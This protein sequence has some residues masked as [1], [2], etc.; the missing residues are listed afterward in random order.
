MPSLL[1]HVC[2][3]PC[4]SKALAGWRRELGLSRGEAR[5]ARPDALPGRGWFFNP[6]IHPLLEFRRRVLAVAVY[7][8]RD[9]FSVDVDADYGLDAFLDDL[10]AP[11]GS[12]PGRRW[13]RPERCFRC[14]ARRLDATAARAKAEGFE[15]FGTTLAA[16]RQQNREA[17]RAMG[18]EAASRRSI[19]FFW[20]DW[21]EEIPPERLTRGLYRQ[22]YCGCVFSE[23]DRHEGTGAYVRRPG[24]ASGA[25]GLSGTG[26]SPDGV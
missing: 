7:A 16:S 24:R 6:N 25:A 19:P 20:R 12:A 18:E 13:R 15:A 1:L 5:G 8:E 22:R 11:D 21:R 23:R 2:C 14:F 26:F 3:A 9:P 17:L 4:L 10:A